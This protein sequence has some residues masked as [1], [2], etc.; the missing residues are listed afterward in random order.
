MRVE[1]LQRTSDDRCLPC[2][3]LHILTLDIAVVPGTLIP[4]LLRHPTGLRGRMLNIV[5]ELRV[6][7]QSSL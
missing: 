2:T 3:V 4:H 5:Q 1:S 6:S 7:F